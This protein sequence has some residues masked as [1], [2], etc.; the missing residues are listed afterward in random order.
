MS[1]IPTFDIEGINWVYPISIGFYDGYDYHDF[2]RKD[3]DDDIIW[4]FLTFVRQYKGIKLFA[5]CASRYDNLFILHALCEHKEPLSL[6]AGM[7]KLKWHGPDIVFEDSYLLAPM[8]LAKLNKMLGVEAKG[9]WNH[10]ETVKPWEMGDKLSTFRT[11]QKTDCITLSESM[12]KL[13]G[14]VVKA[15]GVEPSMTLATT[16]VKTISKAFFDLNQVDN[17]E[18]VEEFVRA[19]TYGARNEIYRRYGENI[20]HFDVH[21]MYTSCYDVPVPVSELRWA[22]PNLDTASVVEAH[23]KIPTDVY[24]GPLPVRTADRRLI[25]PNGELPLS[26]WDAREVRNA[27]EKFNADVIVRR[28]LEADELPV[29]TSFGSYMSSLRNG[30]SALSKYWKLFGVAPSGKFG[31]S[32]WRETTRHASAIKDFT[33]AVPID[34]N[35]LY[36]RK[37][38]YI[39]GRSPYIKPALTMR[40]RAEARIRH[41]DYLLTAKQNGSIYYTDTDSVFCDHEFPIIEKPKSGELAYLG[42]ID[43]GYFVR[44]KLYGMII[45]GALIQKSA[46]Y[47]DLKLTEKNFRDLLEGG[48]VKFDRSDISNYRNVIMNGDLKLLETKRSISAAFLPNRREIGKD[49]EP[50]TL[51]RKDKI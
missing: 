13:C 9:E 17:S 25:F 1:K 48:T 8:K 4:R 19:A 39:K 2:L 34:K 23:V 27:V 37:I 41:L 45:K 50:I 36:F 21:D 44:Q 47:S 46:G 6:E 3:E 32:R 14:E 51:T 24:I 42:K 28:Q 5:H 15:F 31:Q 33:G 7:A 10:E 43:R 35:E 49:S 40:I 30:D 12:S 18:Y 26:W 29:L 22:K 11:Y 16:A 38:E 20:H